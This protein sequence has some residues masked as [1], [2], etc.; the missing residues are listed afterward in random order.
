MGSSS[1]LKELVPL[2]AQRERITFN[3]RALNDLKE[4]ICR[5]TEN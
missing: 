5:K 2:Q 4:R 1:K 3:P